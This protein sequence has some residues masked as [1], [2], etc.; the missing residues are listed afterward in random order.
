MRINECA[1]NTVLWRLC[2]HKGRAGIT[3]YAKY[4]F[5]CIDANTEGRKFF[6]K[7]DYR[8]LGNME[9]T[10]WMKEQGLSHN[11]A[12]AGLKDQKSFAKTWIWSQESCRDLLSDN[13][14][15]Y[16]KKLLNNGQLK[17]TCG[18]IVTYTDDGKMIVNYPKFLKKNAHLTC[19]YILASE[20]DKKDRK[21]RKQARKQ[22]RKKERKKEPR[23]KIKREKLLHIDCTDT[24]EDDDDESDLSAALDA[25]DEQE[26]DDD[27][28]TEDEDES[29]SRYNDTNE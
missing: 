23:R 16:L 24:D 28:A 29:L 6:N 1:K 26:V 3:K 14:R 12:T 4:I 8:I 2:D 25:E 7:D 20:S 9:I 15:N 22:E 27:E 21:E 10:K 5:M 13:L 17:L 18:P 11:A 19:E